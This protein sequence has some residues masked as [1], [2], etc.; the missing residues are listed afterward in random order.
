MVLPSAGSHWAGNRVGSSLSSLVEVEVLA[1]PGELLLAST[2]EGQV[3]D[4]V[5]V[6]L[7]RLDTE[8]R[9]TG[10]RSAS[11]KKAELASKVQGNTSTP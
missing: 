8:G 10:E 2:R 1:G 7:L 4:G 6:E 9:P 3:E 5:R 11:W